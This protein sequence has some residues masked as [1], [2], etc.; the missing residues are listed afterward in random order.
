MCC[1]YTTFKSS[2]ITGFD[3]LLIPGASK[4]TTAGGAPVMLPSNYCGTG[5]GLVTSVK[6]AAL[7]V[8]ICSKHICYPLKLTLVQYTTSIPAQTLPFRLQFVSDLFEAGM[9]MTGETAKTNPGFMLQYVQD[10][11]NCLNSGA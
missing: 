5:Q 3:C 4:A 9:A 11:T 6:A 8:S 2:K 10:S 7:S 1:S